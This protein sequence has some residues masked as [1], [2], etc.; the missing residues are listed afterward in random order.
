MKK[1]VL[2]GDSIRLWGYGTPVEEALKNNQDAGCY[3]WDLL[4]IIKRLQGE[5]E[6]QRKIIEYHD[7][8]QDEVAMLKE[9]RENMQAEIERL[10]ERNYWL[11]SNHEYQC[12]K[13]YF[14]GVEKGKEQAVKDTAKEILQEV[15]CTL[16]KYEVKVH[17]DNYEQF[18]FIY[19]VDSSDIDMSLDKLT[20]RYGV[21]ID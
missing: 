13:S 9:E 1:V 6:A 18:G 21:D 16:R 14:E 7:S 20:K 8:L 5:N 12:E 3:V 2:L 17:K 4:R 10:T 19:M 15:T 11:Q